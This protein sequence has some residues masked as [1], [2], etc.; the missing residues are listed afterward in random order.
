LLAGWPAGWVVGWLGGRLAGES[1]FIENPLIQLGLALLRRVCTNLLV[2][3][4]A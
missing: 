4:W 2:E 1:Y 3:L